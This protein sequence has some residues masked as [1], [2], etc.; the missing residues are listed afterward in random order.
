MKKSFFIPILFIVI[1][2]VFVLFP[3]LHADFTNWDDDSYVINNIAIQNLSWSS[4]SHLFTS[5]HINLY[6]PLV[7][8]SF[9]I[10]YHFAKLSPGVYHATNLFLHITNVILVY[11]FIY[12][13]S[14]KWRVSFL[15]SILFAIHPMHVESVAWISERKDLLYALFFLIAIIIYMLYRRE[16]KT[17]Y[18]YGVLAAFT[19]SLMS[20]PQGLILPLILIL[21]DLYLDPETYVALIREKIPFFA[22]SFTFLAIN[23]TGFYLL[24][25]KSAHMNAVFRLSNICNVLYAH[26]FY[27]QKLLVP[28]KLSCLYPAS[29]SVHCV[30][31]TVSLLVI[32]WLLVVSLRYSRLYVFGVLF[33]LITLLPVSQIIPTGPSIVCDRYTYIPYIGFFFVLSSIVITYFESTFK[34]KYGIRMF[35]AML[36][37][38]WLFSLAFL[39]HKRTK[40]WKDSITLWDNVIASYPNIGVSYVNRGKALFEKGEWDKALKDFNHAIKENASYALA[41]RTRGY[42][43]MRKAF[44]AD[45]RLDFNK[46]IELKPMNAESYYYR[47]YL[48]EVVKKKKMALNDYTSAIELNARHIN[49]LLNRGTLFAE[50]H[51]FEEAIADFT[52]AIKVSPNYKE[53]YYNRGLAYLQLNRL[54][55]ALSD[56]TYARDIDPNFEQ[57]EEMLERIEAMK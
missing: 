41:Y 19:F 47:G 3:V 13:L 45:A 10:E 5:Y 17:V 21:I 2:A 29:Y 12:L 52:S 6:K 39:A 34:Q 32:T 25:P 4:V 48:N 33:F 24:S 42:L 15:S 8:L 23:F 54:K 9:M 50:S 46:A 35:I 26:W 55:E 49:A 20:K 27:L 16:R 36:V 18:F 1:I 37:I 22:I 56:L 14:N 30:V 53:A 28:V 40:V 31:L 43:N 57:A 51:R 7:L 11:I 38:L 44:Y